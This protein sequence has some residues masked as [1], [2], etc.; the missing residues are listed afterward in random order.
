M[1]NEKKKLAPGV[2]KPDTTGVSITPVVKALEDVFHRL[3]GRFFESRLSTPVITVSPDPR[4]KDRLGWCTTR[5]VWQDGQSDGYFE[6]NICAEF[7]NRP[8][9]EMCSTL[10]HEM[11]HLL[12]AEAEV[13]DTSRAGTYHN[14]KFRETAEAHGLMADKTK[15]Q[16]YCETSLTPEAAEFIETLDRTEFILYR[17]DKAAEGESGEPAAKPSSSR[18]YVCPGCGTKI[19]AT[20]DVSIRCESCNVLFEKR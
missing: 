16:G 9:D 5:R 12:N 7:L 14:E 2:S 3:N 10:L 18:R 6:I 15:F 17:E 13:K 4:R 19:T 8:F 1:S 11:C 20:K